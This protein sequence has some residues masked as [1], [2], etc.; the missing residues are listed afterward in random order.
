MF[1]RSM[2]GAHTLQN[3]TQCFR[4]DK[5]LIRSC[6]PHYHRHLVAAVDIHPDADLKYALRVRLCLDSRYGRNVK[7]KT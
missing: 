5:L 4:E 7:K 3:V 1:T 2:L 6:R